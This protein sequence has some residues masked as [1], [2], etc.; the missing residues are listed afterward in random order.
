MI[1]SHSH[2][3]IFIK[4]L[5][6]AGTSIEAAL[7]N[8]C[9]GNDVVVPINDFGHN[10]DSSGGFVHQGMNADEVYR[11]IGQHVDALTIKT[12]LSPE[13]WSNYFKF[14][15]TRNP[16]DR[17]LS[18]FFWDR[19][20][21]PA[22]KPRKRFFHYLGVPFDELAIIKGKF[23]KFVRGGT[24]AQTNDDAFYVSDGPN[25]YRVP[26]EGFLENNDRFYLI[27]DR[28]CVDFVIRYEH[29]QDDFREACRIAGISAVDLP[30]LKTGMRKKQW[31]YTDYYDDGT[32]DIVAALH[33]ND[34]KLFGYQFGKD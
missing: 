33:R 3:F 21:D 30:H 11:K 29:L 9:S 19:R 34:V 6:T 2:K 10:R 28:L 14:S 7:S 23:A 12:R 8:Y 20:K 18:Y 27:D 17:A 13:V 24:L 22:M 31:H 1:I 16:W 5:K 32:R 26:A 4:S 25:R 15:I